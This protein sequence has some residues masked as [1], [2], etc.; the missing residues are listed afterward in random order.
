MSNNI[1]PT[2]TESKPL[3]TDEV[4]AKLSTLAVDLKRIGDRL[5]ELVGQTEAAADEHESACECADAEAD[6]VDFL[7]PDEIAE[8]PEKGGSGREASGQSSE[9]SET[10]EPPPA[11]LSRVVEELRRHVS[12]MN[13]SMT[14]VVG[15]GREVGEL[16]CEL[17]RW[18][19]DLRAFIERVGSE[20]A[21]HA[22]SVHSGKQ[23]A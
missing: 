17:L 7:L 13:R 16:G 8:R 20:N 3:V 4:R 5:T 10:D 15:T 21:S 19:R 23:E 14:E 18:E 11:E 22:G 12:R 6:H 2:T 9:H 1:Q